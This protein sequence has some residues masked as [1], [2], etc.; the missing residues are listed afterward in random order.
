MQTN[1]NPREKQSYI[2]SRMILNRRMKFQREKYITVLR[3]FMKIASINIFS[4]CSSKEKYFFLVN[5]WY[6]KVLCMQSP[7]TH[8]TH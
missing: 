2:F 8:T 3:I 6:F 5:Y 4:K 7:S 1:K